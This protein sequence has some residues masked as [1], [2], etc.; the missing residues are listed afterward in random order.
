M[1][2]TDSKKKLGRFELR[3]LLGGHSDKLGCHSPGWEVRTYPLVHVAGVGEE[4]SR[5][6]RIKVDGLL[7]GR[8]CRVVVLRVGLEP[9]ELLHGRSERGRPRAD[10]VVP[11]VRGVARVL[12]TG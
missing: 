3:V 7:V 4:F 9:L 2:Q 8:A 12:P 1:G 11:H 5:E 6:R 10:L